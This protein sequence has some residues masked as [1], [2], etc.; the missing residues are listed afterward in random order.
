V[1]LIRVAAPVVFSQ[2]SRRIIMRKCRSPEGLECL[3]HRWL[4]GDEQAAAKLWRRHLGRLM[5]LARRR[6]ARGLARHLDAEDLVQAV[7]LKF[8]AAARNHVPALK[9]SDDLWRWLVAIM[10]NKARDHHKRQ[11]ALKRQAGVEEGAQTSLVQVEDPQ[12][13]PPD[14]AALAEELDRLLQLFPAVHR[15]M[16][17]LRLEG[18]KVDDIA[19]A[20][21]G[22]ERTVRR[23]LKRVQTYLRQRWEE[24][25]D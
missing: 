5:G 13:T 12:P 7:Y 15:H 2:I 1:A 9:N 11:H 3:L 14:Q 17:A 25:G 16:V 23:V 21:H 6:F 10:R 20:T 18:W 8:F 22:H 24:L 19:R 4:E